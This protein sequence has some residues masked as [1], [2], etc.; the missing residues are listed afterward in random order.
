MATA[1]ATEQ[2]GWHLKK[3]IQLGHLIT[4]L[5]VATSALWYVAK[6]EQRI[7]IIENQVVNQRDRDAMQDVRSAE[8]QRMLTEQ[9]N[10]MD[11]KLDRLIERRQGGSQ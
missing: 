2:Q 7:A 4:T 1:A 6:L 9:L 10:K 11:A 3:E 5:V 8:T